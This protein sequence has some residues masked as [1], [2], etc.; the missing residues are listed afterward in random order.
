MYLDRIIPTGDVCPG[1]AVNYSPVSEQNNKKT[2]IVY[3]YRG[4][5]SYTGVGGAEMI[6]NTCEDR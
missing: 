5:K 1:A 2:I 3:G 6:R 4:E